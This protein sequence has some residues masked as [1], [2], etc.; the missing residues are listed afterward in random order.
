MNDELESYFTVVCLVIVS[1][2]ILCTRSVTA[3]CGDAPLAG[4]AQV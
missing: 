4:R 2:Y 3:V 1:L